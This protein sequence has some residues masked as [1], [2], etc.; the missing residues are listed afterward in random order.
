MPQNGASTRLLRWRT[1]S[2]PPVARRGLALLATTALLSSGAAGLFTGDAYAANPATV[3]SVSPAVTNNSGDTGVTVTGTGFATQ[4]TAA[5]GNLDTIKFALNDTS[6]SEYGAATPPLSF[7]PKQTDTNS[8]HTSTTY[9]GTLNTTNAAPGYYDVY[10]SNS[11]GDGAKCVK[12]FYIGSQGA[13][14]VN[15]I[16][17]GSDTSNCLPGDP[18]CG[19]V[20]G[21]MAIDIYGRNL[22]KASKVNLLLPSGSPDSG[23]DTNVSAPNIVV[24]DKNNPGDYSGYASSGLMYAE[25]NITSDNFTPGRHLVTVTNTNVTQDVPGGAA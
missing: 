9:T 4:S 10:D 13:P 3:T 16:L 24:L 18:T 17:P 20:R 5:N 1:M 19:N 14:D 22:A 25:V 7:T 11:S 8:T 12:C 21:P 2:L 15:N 23:S 6:N